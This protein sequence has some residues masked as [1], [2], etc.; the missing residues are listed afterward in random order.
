MV[1]ACLKNKYVIRFT[2]TSQYT[3]EDDIKCDWYLIQNTANKIVMENK[4]EETTLSIQQ[5]T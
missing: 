5:K 2:V 1:P 4:N 3:T